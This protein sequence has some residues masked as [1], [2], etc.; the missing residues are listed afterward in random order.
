MGGGRSELPA[1]HGT[2]GVEDEERHARVRDVVGG[3]LVP[4]GHH[5]AVDVFL[6]ELDKSICYELRG[7][8]ASDVLLHLVQLRLGAAR[9]DGGLGHAGAETHHLDSSLGEVEL[10]ESQA[11]L[12]TFHLMV[13]TSFP[14]HLVRVT[15]ELLL[16]LYW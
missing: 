10:G 13:F 9:Q 8:E 15:T 1:D 3:D 14:M 6:K 4:G 7:H 2:G 5:R 16:T 12:Y 11:E